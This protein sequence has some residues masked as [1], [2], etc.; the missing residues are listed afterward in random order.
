MSESEKGKILDQLTIKDN[1]IQDLTKKIEETEMEKAE[2]EKKLASLD[3]AVAELEKKVRNGGGGAGGPMEYS[4]ETV[5]HNK[6]SEVNVDAL[7][8]LLKKKSAEGWILVSTIDDDGGKLLSS[9]GS[10]SESTSLS[11]LASNPF[12]SKED[13]VVLI[14]ARPLNK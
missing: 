2:L 7:A 9:M 11:S 8:K 12:D 1:E 3:N 10:S 13:R 4:V 5:E 14:F 6:A